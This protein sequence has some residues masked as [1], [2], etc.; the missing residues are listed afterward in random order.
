SAQIESGHAHSETVRDLIENDAL[1]AVG[2]FAIDL[3]SAVDGAR[4]HDQA[5]R[6]QK[7]CAFFGQ[8]KQPN[9][10]AEPG[11]IFSALAFVL[12]PQKVYDI[13]LRSE[14]HTSELQSPD[15]LV[16]RLL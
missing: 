13:G 7:F 11:K 6:F 16:C 1:Q 2:Y 12:N 5:I 14:E 3:D 15:H 10:F 8:A 4:V 9:V